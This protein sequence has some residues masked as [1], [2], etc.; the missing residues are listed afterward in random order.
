MIEFYIHVPSVIIGFLLGYGVIAA[1]L[2]SLMFGEKWDAGFSAGWR[3]C[4]ERWE[5]KTKDEQKEGT[6]EED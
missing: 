5:R 6:H 2:L 1:A 3:S 4:N